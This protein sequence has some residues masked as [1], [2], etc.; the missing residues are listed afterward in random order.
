MFM[1]MSPH[2]TYAVL[3]IYCSKV[4]A[5]C[6]SFPVEVEMTRRVLCYNEF[7]WPSYRIA[8]DAAVI[9]WYVD[10][11]ALVLTTV[12]FLSTLKFQFP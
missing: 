7:K 5:D 11:W 9:E 2:V 4:V 6:Q 3:A 12:T 1:V 10:S 8:K